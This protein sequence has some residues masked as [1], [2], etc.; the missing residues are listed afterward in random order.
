MTVETIEKIVTKKCK[1][2]VVKDANGN[3]IK[4]TKK[5]RVDADF[6]PKKIDDICIEFIANY[7]KANKQKEWFMETV[8]KKT[9]AK[10][11]VKDEN[12]KPTGE[13]TIEEID[14]P[15]V[16]VRADFANKFF[17][18]IIKGTPEKQPTIKDRFNDDFWND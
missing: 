2:K 17:P 13:V 15:F 14:Y 1:G 10:K 9:T 3:S 11:K 4:V 5:F 18:S 8:N 16:N 7:C 12:G 6:K